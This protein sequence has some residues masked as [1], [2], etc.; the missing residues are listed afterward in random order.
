MFGSYFKFWRV[1]HHTVA[2]IT[3]ISEMN[4]KFRQQFSAISYFLLGELLARCKIFSEMNSQIANIIGEMILN[5]IDFCP[6]VS[7]SPI[8]Y[9][10]L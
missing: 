10:N 4:L 6:F 9:Y 3:R 2:E 1:L 7:I 5:L 8:T